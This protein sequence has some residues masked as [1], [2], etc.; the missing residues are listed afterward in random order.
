MLSINC[1]INKC[2]ELGSSLVYKAFYGSMHKGADELPSKRVP[3]P[4]SARRLTVPRS[5]ILPL[6]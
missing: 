4:H 3:G 6:H 1:I 5:N 2:T